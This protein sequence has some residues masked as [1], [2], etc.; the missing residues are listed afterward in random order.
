M[1]LQ[2][3]TPTEH[4][5][6]RL[7]NKAGIEIKPRKKMFLFFYKGKEEAIR[8]EN[9]VLLELVFNGGIKRLC[10]YSTSGKKNPNDHPAWSQ[11]GLHCKYDFMF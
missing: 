7:F 5:F 4:T 10:A 11:Q 9:S 8:M 2:P 1:S 6:R 3:Q